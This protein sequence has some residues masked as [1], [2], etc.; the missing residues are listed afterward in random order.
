MGNLTVSYEIPNMRVGIW[1]ANVDM[2]AE[3]TPGFPGTFQF[4][5]VVLA[6]AAAG[7]DGFAGA[8]IQAPA[9]S[10]VAILGILQD[11]PKQNVSGD[12]W[13][14]GISKAVFGA[15]ITI[16]QL[17]MV[18]TSGQFVPATSGNFAVA[19]ALCA[20]SNGQIGS[21]WLQNFGKQ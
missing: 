3:P 19:M 9:A 5:G 13:L 12:I 6:A 8:G 16:N 11:N 15:T 10:G 17:L 7:V 18:N 21:V 20:G 2:S 14:Q 4:T 1:P